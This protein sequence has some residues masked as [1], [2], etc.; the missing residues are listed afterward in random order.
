MS[1][2]NSRASVTFLNARLIST[3]SISLVLF[4][5]GLI[6][7]LGL[8][9]NKLSYYVKENLSFSVVLNEEMKE[10]QILSMQKR[11]E[12]SSFVKSATYISKEQAAKELEEDLGE[13]PETFL[14]YNPLLP[15]IEIRLKADYANND[16][17][18]VIDKKI[19]QNSNIQ[20]IVY[21]QDLL[22]LV[23]N[24]IRK[25]GVILLILA[26][27][28]MA[29][30][31][32]LISNTIRLAI[33]SKRFLIHT[34]K[35]VGATNGF[36]RKPFVQSNIVTGIIAAIIA[37][38]MLSGVVYYLSFEVGN[39]LDLMNIDMLLVVFAAVIVLGVLL[40]AAATFFAVNR[41]LRMESDHLYYI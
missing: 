7:L 24:N 20:D 16:S 22:Q 1:K 31:F 6:V 39:L 34:M 10:P 18:S 26:V 25:A 4:L 35:L 19:R 11:L 23:N 36:I 40:S 5:L 29:I 2:K 12:T 41:Y 28:L 30:S 13:S 27:I 8:F 9:A 17:I 21:R 15:S 32:A 3:I 37:I 33:Y 38:C 14:G